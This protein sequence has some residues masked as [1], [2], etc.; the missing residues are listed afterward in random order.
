MTAKAKRCIF[1]ILFLALA[2]LAFRQ[3]WVKLDPLRNHPVI[4]TWWL[5]HNVAQLGSPHSAT[6]VR[7]WNEL[8]RIYLS[9][10]SAYDWLVWRVKQDIWKRDDPPIHF[11]LRQQ[12]GRYYAAAGSAGGDCRTVTEA[13]MAIL[14]QEPT[15]RTSYQG[16]WRKWWD[17]N[18]TYFPNRQLQ[19]LPSGPEAPTGRR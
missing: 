12:G 6:A 13:L 19:A 15:R 5:G 4:A 7:A 10:W 8:E 18:W 16:D 9:K 3:I 17:A 2:A 11:Q 1:W 14:H